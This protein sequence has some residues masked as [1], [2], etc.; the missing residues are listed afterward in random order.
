MQ[1]R[2]SAIGSRPATAVQLSGP[3]AKENPYSAPALPRLA[4]C[5]LAKSIY[6]PPSLA[7]LGGDGEKVSL[8]YDG[9]LCRCGKG[10]GEDKGVWLGL[11][12]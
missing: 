4:Y 3:S 11:G 2:P 1:V 7:L 9:G 5:P 12:G 10:N 6:A 8:F